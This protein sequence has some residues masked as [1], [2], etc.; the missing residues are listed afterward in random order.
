M[1]CP[2]LHRRRVNSLRPSIL[3]ERVE[4]PYGRRN[5]KRKTRLSVSFFLVTQRRFELWTPCLKGRCSAD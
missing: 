1:S 2:S 3:I 5:P 4:P